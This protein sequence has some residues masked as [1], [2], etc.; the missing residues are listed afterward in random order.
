MT[1]HERSDKG[2]LLPFTRNQASAQ[3]RCAL[4][5]S[6]LQAHPSWIN[7]DASDPPTQEPKWQIRHSF[8]LSPFLTPPTPAS[9]SLSS[10]H[11]APAWR[12]EG[13][14]S[15]DRTAIATASPPGITTTPRI[16]EGRRNL[17]RDGGVGF[18]ARGS[19]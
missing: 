17:E 11:S 16:R 7:S 8:S 3:G 15:T 6:P 14:G 12:S 2:Y 19:C 9:T 4:P 10:R 5:S 13:A 1:S 18:A